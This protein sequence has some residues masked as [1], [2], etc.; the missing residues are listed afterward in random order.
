M[1]LTDYVLLE[2]FDFYRHT[3]DDTLW[4]WHVLVH[5]CRRWRQIVFESPCRFDLNIR[6]T[7]QTPARENLGIWPTFPIAI[8]FRSTSFDSIPR[9]AIAA[10]EHASR[11]GSL[12]LDLTE[13]RSKRF[14]TLTSKPFPTLTHLVLHVKDGHT[15]LISSDFLGG[16]APR[17]QTI[18]L[19]NITFTALQ[20]LLLSS[21]DLVELQLRR[22][23]KA[24]NM[25][26]PSAMVTCL[27]QLL[28]LKTLV[29]QFRSAFPLPVHSHPVTQ[30]VLPALT[31]FEF[32]GTSEY[33]EDFVAQIDCPRLNQITIMY[34][35]RPAVF[36]VGQLAKFFNRSISP[37]KH[38]EICFDERGVTFDLYR[39]TNPIGRDS[40]QPATAIISCKPII[41]AWYL[42][43]ILHE[44][45]V[46]L[47]TVVDL[48][49]VGESWANGSI[50]GD[51]YHR[52]W[53]HFFRQT[54]ALQALYVPPQL[55]EKIGRALKSVKGEAVAEA[56]PSLDLICLEDQ[57]SYIEEF[58]A[59]RLFSNCPLTVVGT[60]AEFDRR[61]GKKLRMSYTH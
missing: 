18:H 14:A 19:R 15:S 30:S 28:R 38:A 37:F 52:E 34:H 9:D 7:P 3:H 51:E 57:A 4:E 5:V 58:V 56:L 11:I 25:I 40:H 27:A 31:N 13:L 8:D 55:A 2:I 60:E 42:F 44:L 32:L 36:Q 43:C 48:K 6:C 12:K 49:F 10:L 46:M 20:T 29:L 26:F 47:V 39:P 17:L 1:I 22:I 50:V 61:L 45:S 16:S 53:L 24:G 59:V 23:P 35:I 41:S 21:S 33:L 54:S